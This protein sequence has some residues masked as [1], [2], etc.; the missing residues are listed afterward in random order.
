MRSYQ[1]VP[2]RILHWSPLLLGA[3]MLAACVS[4]GG[5]AGGGGA[6]PD[7][8]PPGDEVSVREPDQAFVRAAVEAV[9]AYRA[10]PR[11]C[12]DSG[13][14]LPAAPPVTWSDTL[15]EAA[16]AHSADMARHEFMS[17]RGT[18]GLMP[19]NRISNAGYTWRGW[20]ENVAA[21]HSRVDAV[22]KGWIDS[23]GHCANIMRPDLVEIGLGLAE[24]QAAEY[25]YYWTLKLAAPRE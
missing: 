14:V 15:G 16:A 8:S 7:R 20:A 5:D 25:R 2:R 17:H 6:S 11:T 1:A 19:G 21:G 12:E 22:M 18:D 13:D 23:P 3:V 24:N 10:E 4:A 9:N